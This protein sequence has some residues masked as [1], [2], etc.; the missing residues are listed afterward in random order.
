MR[1]AAPASLASLE[2]QERELAQALRETRAQLTT[3]RLHD[4]VLTFLSKLPGG[5]SANK[6]TLAV[7]GQRSAV[8]RALRE[9]EAAGRVAVAIAPDR[10]G[11]CWVFRA[12]GTG[13]T[14]SSEQ[15]PQLRRVRA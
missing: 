13:C 1:R 11:L 4:R 15:P 8:Y 10:S 14:K 6:V 9:L 12:P 3:R 7:R 5:A 2:A